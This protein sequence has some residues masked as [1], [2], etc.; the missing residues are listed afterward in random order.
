MVNGFDRPSLRIGREG[1][2]FF[3]CKDAL[4]GSECNDTWCAAMF[5]ADV[6][7]YQGVH[8]VDGAGDRS[9]ERRHLTVLF[10][11]LVGSTGLARTLDPEEL[12]ELLF[13]QIK[14]RER[15]LSKQLRVFDRQE[16]AA[17]LPHCVSPI[18]KRRTIST[19]SGNHLVS[20]DSLT[21]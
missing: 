6:R 18:R 9:V 15:T 7:L 21:E 19:V 8:A 12:L 1:S 2:C 17:R 16:R 4:W 20:F 11:D 10:T 14:P 5:H 13:S 3:P